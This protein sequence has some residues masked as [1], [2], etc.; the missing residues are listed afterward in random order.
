MSETTIQDKL[1]N[2]TKVAEGRGITSI[3]IDPNITSWL[4][5][6]TISPEAYPKGTVRMVDT[7]S[8]TKEQEMKDSALTMSLSQAI[9]YFTDMIDEG[10]FDT[11]KTYRT[12]FLDDAHTK[13]GSPLRLYCFRSSDGT[14]RVI[15]LRVRPGI[16]WG[17]AGSGWIAHN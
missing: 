7:K 5:S 3:W 8:G 6:A 15:V 17:V 13:D 16:T 10:V 11:E 12:I 1:D 2:L 9:D 4:P 14:L